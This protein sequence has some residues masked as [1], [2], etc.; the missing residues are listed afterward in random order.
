MPGAVAGAAPRQIGV[1][2]IV[3]IARWIGMRDHLWRPRREWQRYFPRLARWRGRSGDRCRRWSRRLVRSSRCTRLPSLHRWSCYVLHRNC[4]ARWS[5]LRR[6]NY[7][8]TTGPGKL[9]SS[10]LSA[11]SCLRDS[12]RPGSIRELGR[13]IPRHDQAPCGI[14]EVVT[15]ADVGCRRWREA[16]ICRPPGRPEPI[17]RRGR[18]AD[19][20]AARSVPSLRSPPYHWCRRLGCSCRPFPSPTPVVSRRPPVPV[21]DRP[22]S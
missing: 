1:H 22:S 11:G 15:R 18:M 21:D 17:P 8:P 3:P 14:S 5:C 13:R 12:H 19:P 4:R 9:P 2:R 16:K 20:S 10:S 6:N 7:W